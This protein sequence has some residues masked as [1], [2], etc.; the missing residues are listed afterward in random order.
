MIRMTET[1]QQMET[2]PQVV[3]FERLGNWL[4][5]TRNVVLPLLL[6][7]LLFCFPPRPFH[8]DLAAD[9]WLDGAGILLALLGQ[10]LRAITIGYKYIVRGCKGGKVYADDLV[11]SGMFAHARNP[12]YVGNLLILAGLIVIHNNPWVYLI[13]LPAV[14]CFYAAI[15]AAEE[16]YLRKKFGEEYVSYCRRVPRWI[17][18]L[19]GFRES[20]R[21]IPFNW[22]EVLYTEL[23]STYTWVVMMLALLAYEFTQVTALPHRNTYL[24][25]LLG[26]FAMT[27]AGWAAWRYWKKWLTAQYRL[28]AGQS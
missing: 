5:K 9:L 8:E 7:V 25:V 17:P 20:V 4:F 14:G 1:T 19:K 6:L 11:T 27:T 10:T 28:R 18:R 13:G 12:L 2:S 15:V 21:D 3:L 26:L 16:A 24:L 23:G 22:E